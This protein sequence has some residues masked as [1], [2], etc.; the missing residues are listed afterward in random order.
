MNQR[1]KEISLK[2]V[3]AIFMHPVADISIVVNEC[4]KVC[5]EE[6][7]TKF[8]P[9]EKQNP[10]IIE[11]RLEIVCKLISDLP[12]EKTKKIAFDAVLKFLV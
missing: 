4:L 12:K 6:L 10:R 5:K 9:V 8:V 3:I 11:S 1:A 7:N 2:T